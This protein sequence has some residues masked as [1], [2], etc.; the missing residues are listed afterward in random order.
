MGCGSGKIADFEN[1]AALSDDKNL[2]RLWRN[3][4]I[5]GYLEDSLLRSYE[6]CNHRAGLSLI[7]LNNTAKK[8]FIKFITSNWEAYGLCS[9]ADFS[10]WNGENLSMSLD[11]FVHSNHGNLPLEH[12]MQKK[13]LTMFPDFLDSELYD[14][15]RL[16]EHNHVI[17]AYDSKVKSTP[18][19]IPDMME[20]H[21]TPNTF[22]RATAVAPA[23]PY[24]ARTITFDI[25]TATAC[26]ATASELPQLQIDGSSGETT[27]DVISAADYLEIENI[28]SCDISLFLMLSTMENMPVS[29]SL[30][31]AQRRDFPI[32]YANKHFETLT[33]YKR[34]EVIGKSTGFLRIDCRGM[35]FSEDQ[36]SDRLDQAHSHAHPAVTK[37][38]LFRRNG[39]QYQCLY[40]VKPIFNHKGAYLFTVN[41]QFETL[42]NQ[43]TRGHF[44]N[45]VQRVL[46]SVPDHV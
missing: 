7:L 40:A 18:I 26:S 23:E 46:M 3:S 38:T 12:E 37:I 29:F 27:K 30:V 25:T 11:F 42:S 2:E 20:E 6:L 28:M 9:I 16:E 41:F 39:E 22:K 8:L 44:I 32:I 5:M 14:D 10:D 17:R 35:R 33:G 13:I 21:T 1:A 19:T 45:F 31:S 24:L 36:A 34:Y 4:A 15:W 43:P